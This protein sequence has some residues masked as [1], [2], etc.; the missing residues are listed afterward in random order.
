MT[1]GSCRERERP[2][3]TKPQLTNKNLVLGPRWDLTPQLTGRLNISRNVT[4]T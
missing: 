2:T 4:L 1:D 3:S